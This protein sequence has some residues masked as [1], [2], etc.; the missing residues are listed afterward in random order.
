MASCSAQ[1]NISINNSVFDDAMEDLITI[2][3]VANSEELQT[4]SRLSGD[5]STIT[6]RLR[7]IAG[8]DA[9]N[10]GVWASGVEFTKF[11]QYMI[12]NGTAY[13]P[14]PLQ[15]LPVLSGAAPDTSTFEPFTLA[16][17]SSDLYDD[18]DDLLKL[19]LGN[20]TDYAFL[21]VDDMML[22]ITVGGSKIKFK[23]NQSL[24]VNG[25]NNEVR[26]YVVRTSLPGISLG[27]GLYASEVFARISTESADANSPISSLNADNDASNFPVPALSILY[28]SFGTTSNKFGAGV[29]SQSNKIYMMPRLGTS[30]GKLNVSSN[31]FSEFGSVSAM[32]GYTSGCLAANGK[33]Y[34]ASTGGSNVLE[35]NPNND[36]V[37]EF[38]LSNPSNIGFDG[39][40]AASNGLVYFVPAGATQV[41]ELNTAT[42][43]T[44]YIGSVFAATTAK[45]AGGV[46][47][48]NGKIYCAPS[49][50]QSILEIDPVTKATRLIPIVSSSSF[51]SWKG[52]TLGNDGKIYFIPHSANE[53]LVYDPS[54]D[55]VSYIAVASS[56]SNKWAGGVMAKNGK[57]YGMP[58][59]SLN[60][61]EIDTS[62]G[63]VAEYVAPVVAGSN[64]FFG[65]VM[66]I[67]GIIY[68][69]PANGSNAVLVIDGVEGS[70]SWQLS[71][72]SNKY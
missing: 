55:S 72:Y 66:S 38:L 40:V 34:A 16:A 49:D 36:S 31:T 8:Y 11:D 25:E 18:I 48:G 5:V 51:G 10:G 45:W 14:K 35:I 19:E 53:V 70:V 20:Y 68:G 71:A 4:P 61:L 13:K 41:V 67:D 33:I 29:L 21:S 37:V 15:P 26:C 46:I 52:G 3:N 23:S 7:D 43:Q 1:S 62:T 59:A 57:I 28:S 9:I 42:L 65:G 64:K 56:G 32:Q 22:G 17:S 50:V 58:Y 6:G 39:A 24:K 2:E 54:G 69:M 27:A 47:A 44:T 12:Y 30:V 60:A 63:T